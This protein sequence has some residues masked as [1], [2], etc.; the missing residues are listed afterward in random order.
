MFLGAFT[1]QS[2]KESNVF[3]TSVIKSDHI[4]IELNVPES[5]LDIVRLNLG[6]IIHDY[7]DIM[8]Y[9]TD[10]DLSH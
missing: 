10:R 1:N 3:P 7:E 4:I 5:E 8:G 2:N 6:T 9:F